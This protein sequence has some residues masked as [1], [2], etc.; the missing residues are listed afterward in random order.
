[1]ILCYYFIYFLL[2]LLTDGQTRV[3]H[4]VSVVLCFHHV[5]PEHPTWLLALVVDV[6]TCWAISL[7]LLSSMLSPTVMAITLG[8]R[9]Q[10]LELWAAIPYGVIELNEE[11]QTTR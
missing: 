8:E 6:F 9:I 2:C 5:K 7:I 3:H 4:Y 11:F 10:L 1:M